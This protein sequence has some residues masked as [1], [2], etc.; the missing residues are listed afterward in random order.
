MNKN[1]K[2]VMVSF[3][4]YIIGFPISLLIRRSNNY[5]TFWCKIKEHQELFMHNTKYLFLYL[6]NIENKY[7]YKLNWICN[8]AKM[9]KYLNSKGYKNVRSSHS[10]LGIFYALKSKFWL[11]DFSPA[12]LDSILNFNATCVNLWHGSG[13]LKVIADTRLKNKFAEKFYKTFLIKDHYFMTVGEVDKKCVLESIK[14]PDN[15]IKI[16][17]F[18]RLDVLFNEFK[19]EDLFMENEFK[20]IKQFKK[21]GKKLLIYVPTHR[22]SDKNIYGWLKN[23]IL[24]KLL[25]ENNAIL[26]CKLHFID[27]NNIN[28]ENKNSI[29]KIN[30]QSDLQ[31]ILRLCDGL[32]TDYSSVYFDYLLLNRP[33]IHYVPDLD[34]YQKNSPFYE[35]FENKAAG[36]ITFNEDELLNSINNLLNDNDAFKDKRDTLLR[37][38]YLYFDNKNCERIINFL[39]SIQR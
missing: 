34:E 10:L 26:L 2:F 17:G 4:R 14:L 38:T 29:Y 35:P 25:E 12:Y 11:H 1:I 33:I 32:I 27:A 5:I 36:S 21:Q 8:D 9:R 3:L 7:N 23:P 13:G 19:D 22:K 15:Q 30:S 24:N 20:Q 28:L 39:W 37:K 18:P 16:L 31:P 6:N